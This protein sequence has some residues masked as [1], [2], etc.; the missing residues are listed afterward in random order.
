MDDSAAVSA[1]DGA[2]AA[3]FCEGISRDSAEPD[4]SSLAASARGEGKGELP[5]P[6]AEDNKRLVPFVGAS[7]ERMGDGEPGSVSITRDSS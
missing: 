5:P 3:G 1:D 6:P 7:A 4:S 2:A